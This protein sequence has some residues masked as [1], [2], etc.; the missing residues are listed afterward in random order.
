MENDLV[1]HL[2]I[3]R[4]RV[5][6]TDEAFQAFI[7]AFRDLSHKLEGIVSFE[8]GTNN[9]TEGLNHGMTHVIALTFANV[10][11]RDDYLLH[12][13]HQKF[14]EWVSKL[15]IIDE[16]LVIDYNPKS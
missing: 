13:E 9:S 4:F 8:F 6:T 1:R 16:M 3:G 11:K 10:Q 12:P 2:L 14:A 7:M 15:N 5:G